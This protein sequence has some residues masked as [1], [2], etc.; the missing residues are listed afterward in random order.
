MQPSNTSGP[1]TTLAIENVGPDVDHAAGPP[2]V[3]G[4]QCPVCGDYWVRHQKI[5][6]AKCE[7]TSVQVWW[8]EAMCQRCTTVALKDGKRQASAYT[9]RVLWTILAVGYVTLVIWIIW[10][11]NK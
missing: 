2:V 9:D 1:W 11:F 3:C 10:N 7:A 8:D 4:Y 5:A 6:E